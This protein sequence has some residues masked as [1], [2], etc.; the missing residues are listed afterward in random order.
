MRDFP[1]FPTEYGVASLI[2][3]EIPYRKTAYIT[4]QASQELEKLLE[5]CAGF[6]RMCGAEQVWATGVDMPEGY[7]LHTAVYEMTC[8]TWLDEE[9][10]A[11]CFPVTEQTV[12][13]WRQIYNE[14]MAGVD[15][16]ATL[17]GRDEEKIL[18]SGGA[19][20]VHDRGR[21]LGIGWVE[22]ST[23][24]A[25]A[26][27]EPGAGER[28]MHTMMSLLPGQVMRLEVA[29]TNARAIRLYEGLGFVKTREV[30]R[31]YRV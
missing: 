24:L 5:E 17:E 21:L 7:P 4:I 30:F 28:V 3:K 9:K 29:S 27:V 14:R 6:A 8:Q 19:Y 10:L 15:N 11:C 20:F 23:L 18:T 22:E 1:V 31:W 16:A 25:M 13:R 26:A 12:G 2:L